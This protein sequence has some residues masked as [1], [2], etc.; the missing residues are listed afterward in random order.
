[1]RI[2]YI[3]LIAML[4]LMANSFAMTTTCPSS[5]E[6][7]S[8]ILML[9]GKDLNPMF[10]NKGLIVEKLQERFKNLKNPNLKTMKVYAELGKGPWTVEYKEYPSTGVYTCRYINGS[11]AVIF[12]FTAD[13]K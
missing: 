6:V 4:G 10:I 7:Q 8:I 12:E 3:P 9:Q 1:M 13:L 11:K 2:I 5:P